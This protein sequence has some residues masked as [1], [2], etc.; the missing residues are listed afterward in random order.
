MFAKGRDIMR[1]ATRDDDT[2]WRLGYETN[3]VADI[4]CPE[5]CVG[6]EDEGIVDT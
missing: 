2:I 1:D 4:V 5:A 6:I 3:G